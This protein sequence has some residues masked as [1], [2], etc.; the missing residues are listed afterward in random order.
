MI[1]FG[2]PKNYGS[3]A[4]FEREELRPMQKVGFSVADLEAEATFTAGHDDWTERA[5]AELDFD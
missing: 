5:P 3:F 2:V 1:P 4:E